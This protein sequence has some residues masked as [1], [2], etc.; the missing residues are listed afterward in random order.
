MEPLHGKPAGPPEPARG[1]ESANWAAPKPA[2]TGHDESAAFLALL[3]AADFELEVGTDRLR[4]GSS[5]G[6]RW[7]SAGAELGTT[8]T[9]WLRQ[10]RP[11]DQSAVAEAFASASRGPEAIRQPFRISLAGVG[12]RRMV[13]QAVRASD[14][15]KVVG[16]IQDVTERDV[17]IEQQYTNALLRTMRSF[18]HD[19]NT[20]LASVLGYIQI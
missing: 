2:E 7:P 3:N 17:E 14:E 12:E 5:L 9:A 6:A 20:P 8:L 15:T 16:V 10:L 19:I 18:R 4:W 11:E 13:L 1:M